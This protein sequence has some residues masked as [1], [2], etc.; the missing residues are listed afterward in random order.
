MVR[1]WVGGAHRTEQYSWICRMSQ[2]QKGNEAIEPNWWFPPYKGI[3]GEM[4]IVSKERGSQVIS[5]GEDEWD[6]IR[7]DAFS[8]TQ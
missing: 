5:V 6:E 8:V 4:W 3:E 7:V 2:R 1:E